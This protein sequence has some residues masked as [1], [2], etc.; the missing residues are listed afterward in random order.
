MEKH[1]KCKH[2]DR[3]VQYKG[4]RYFLCPTANCVCCGEFFGYMCFTFT[5]GGTV[6]LPKNTCGFCGGARREYSDS[7]SYKKLLEKYE[8]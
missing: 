1:F 7:S 3:T 2:G 4:T 8:G 5:G 6:W